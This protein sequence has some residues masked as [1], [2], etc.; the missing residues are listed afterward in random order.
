MPVSRRRAIE[1]ASA[2]AAVAALRPSAALAARPGSFALDLTAALPRGATAAG[3]RHVLPVMTAP[4]RFDLVGLDFGP[5]A[6]VHAELRAR[7][8][9]A[10]WSPWV[11]LHDATQ[12]CWTGP[13]DLFQVRFTGAA[14]RLRARFVRAGRVTPVAGAS[15]KTKPAHSAAGGPP[16]ILDRAS[17]GGDRL[18]PKTD[19][20]H[21]DVQVG[22]V[23][24]TVTANDYGP[25]DSA[26]IV[27]GICRYHRDHNG[28]N[29]IGYNF[30][31]DK[32]GQIFE[33]RDGGIDQAIVGAQAQGYNA[34]STG[35]SCLGDYSVLALPAAG[36]EAVARLLAWKLPLHGVP[37]T[38]RV[39][40][41]SEGGPTNRF[42]SGT[43]VSL[44][45]ISGHRDGD[46]TSCPGNG[47]Y[48]SLETLRARTDALAVPLSA[49]TVQA[50]RTE[51][52]YPAT[53]LALSGALRFADGAPP[54]GAP[55]QVQYQAR[56]GSAWGLVQTLTADPQGAFAIG[57][58]V[59][60][61][62]RVRAVFPGD[63]IH[64]PITA[65]PITVS[66]APQLTLALSPRRLRLGRATT[67]NGTIGPTW[68]SRAQLTIERRVGRRYYLVR[69]KRVRVSA[70]K[71]STTFRPS[72]KGLFRVTLQAGGSTI[73]RLVRAV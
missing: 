57:V 62:G 45:R 20:L 56:A 11:A 16:P 60:A 5:A 15:A 40:V 44:Q 54:A 27:L 23:H 69:R 61:S 51:L 7:R 58:A 55:L 26:S 53:T 12:P 19:P 34:H 1:L 24:H 46:A 70:G 39:T 22:F 67:I 21:G 48:G 71:L 50:D 49:L 59:P 68:P 64:G 73:R 2:A 30:L 47:I 6:H 18:P 63:A 14:R 32:Y 72:S 66:V 13:A 41:A 65:V 43:K 3:A 9:G 38:G 25:G 37:V 31:V 17:W 35:V 29:D 42:R 10:A 28:W 33:G 36:M 8:R 4:R 52:R